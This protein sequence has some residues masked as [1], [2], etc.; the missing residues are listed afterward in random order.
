[1][2][3]TSIDLVVTIVTDKEA[4]ACSYA[5][6]SL[7][8][9]VVTIASIHVCVASSLVRAGDVV[10][11]VLTEVLVFSN[12]GRA[13]SSAICQGAYPC[14]IAC[15]TFDIVFPHVILSKVD[16]IVAFFAV[17][18]TVEPILTLV[19]FIIAISAPDVLIA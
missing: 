3:I 6:V 8:D 13:F 16:G 14:V 11:S 2:S 10:V 4:I 17:N 9:V 7:N 15:S 12:V 5:V 1:V 19:D 18:F